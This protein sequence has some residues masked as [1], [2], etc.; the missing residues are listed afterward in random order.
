MMGS[1]HARTIC[2]DFDGVIA[3][4]SKGWQ[5]ADVFG[6]PLPGVADAL[7]ELR[8]RGWLIILF[9]TRRHTRKLE[10]YIHFHNLSIDLG[11]REEREMQYLR[12]AKNRLKIIKDSI[13]YEFHLN[14]KLL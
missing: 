13:Y 10:R 5:G 14:E 8:K 7:L 11:E 2:V 6:D 12:E 1:S 4:Y 9:T 3:D